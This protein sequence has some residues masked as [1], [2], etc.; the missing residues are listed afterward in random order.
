MCESFLKQHL[1]CVVSVQQGLCMF[2]HVKQKGSYFPFCLRIRKTNRIPCWNHFW[3]IKKNSLQVE[4]QYGQTSFTPHWNQGPVPK[5]TAAVLTLH[6]W[7]TR[8]LS[9]IHLKCS[10]AHED[11]TRTAF[12]YGA[13]ADAVK[14]L[15]THLKLNVC[16]L[17]CMWQVSEFNCDA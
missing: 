6:H 5:P 16:L 10:S 9:C 1:K 12:V 11:H 2:I 8:C 17:V 7:S 15:L 13:D 4:Y 14:R 3:M